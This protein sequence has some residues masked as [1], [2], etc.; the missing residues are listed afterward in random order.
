LGSYTRC[1]ASTLTGEP[2]AGRC[3]A[4][5]G[6][7]GPFFFLSV[8]SVFPARLSALSASAD[9]GTK[10][11]SIAS[12]ITVRQGKAHL[13][14]SLVTVTSFTAPGSLLRSPT[15]NPR[16]PWQDHGFFH[17]ITPTPPLVRSTFARHSAA[18][19]RRRNQSLEESKPVLAV[20]AMKRDCRGR[21]ATD[22]CSQMP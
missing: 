15:R 7:W 16:P 14:C 6:I 20:L 3:S 4:G 19:F 10:K 22:K 1:S 21:H 8:F 18:Q 11:A 17:I 9:A 12:R 2:L 13:S 5:R